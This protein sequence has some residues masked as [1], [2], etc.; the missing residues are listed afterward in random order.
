MP[1]QPADI[2]YYKSIVKSALENNVEC[3]QALTALKELN[4]LTPEFVTRTTTQ[5]EFCLVG[6]TYTVA[7]TG[8]FEQD[9][10]KGLYHD[11]DNFASFT[12]SGDVSVELPPG[13]FYFEG[14]NVTDWSGT[15]SE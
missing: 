13:D 11:G 10:I 7:V 4:A 8:T 14:S 6:G 5:E 2:R 3:G 12:D 15:V 1:K 9:G